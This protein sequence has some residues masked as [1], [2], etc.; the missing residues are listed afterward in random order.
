MLQKAGGTFTL[1][2][3]VNF[4]ASFGVQSVYYKS[5]AAAV[6]T[7]GVVRLGNTETIGWRNGAD[8]ANLALGVSSDKI[9]FGGIDLADV[10]SA[11]TLTNKTFTSA[12]LT[13]PQIND[14]SA[15]HQ[16]IFA[17]SEL[18]ADRTVTLPLL[19]GNDTFVFAAHSQTLTNKTIDADANTITNIENADIKSGAAIAV[20]KLAAVT[21]SRAL[22]S[23]GSGFVS[24]SAVT[25]TELGY[26]TGVSAGIQIQLGLKA[27][28]QL[29]NLT[30][31]NINTS[32]ISDADNT[33]DLGND[34]REWK[35]LWVHSI[36]HNDATDTAL[37]ISTTGSDGNITINPHG[38]GIVSITKGLDVNGTTSYVKIP[39]LTTAQRDALTPAAGMIIYNTSLGTIQGYTSSW[40]SFSS[41][42]EASQGV[43]GL[44]SA[45]Q[46][47]GTNTNDNAASGYVGEY[48]ES[49]VTSSQNAASTGAYLALASI[50][51][52]AGDWDIT[53]SVALFRNS[54]TFNDQA[55]MVINT[56][57]ASASGITDGQRN[58]NYINP[59]TLS[60][61]SVTG[62][63][64]ANYR[65]S[66]SSSTTY[67]LNVLASY[68]AGTP[69]WRGALSARRVR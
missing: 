7:A 25:D 48:V 52:S 22:V 20:N 13:T 69:R 24:A 45:G 63:T 27:A 56:T 53:G 67:F 8:S 35:D 50:T 19:A 60:S 1:T 12:V 3:D 68:S 29:S 30:S 66:I 42:A 14:T 16:Y 49:V 9:Q 15:D 18:A 6:S 43:L 40:A 57:T 10:S 62:A 46:W 36:K 44:V 54:A 23:D 47:R 4:G 34:G 64:I 17:V 41:A 55:A 59:G 38:S 5:L 28:V 2:A 37:A 33:D 58:Q 26:L 61:T 65:V 21:A 51:L 11:Q 39:S 31:T 32:L